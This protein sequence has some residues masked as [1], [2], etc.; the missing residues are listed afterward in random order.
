MKGGY[1]AL[2]APFALARR[3]MGVLGAI[4]PIAVLSMFH[5]RQELSNLLL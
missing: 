3:L 4:V 5:A 2:H 1:E